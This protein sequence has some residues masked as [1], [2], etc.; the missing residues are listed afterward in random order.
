M[1]ETR[2]HIYTVPEAARH[3]RLSE[4]TVRKLI[5]DGALRSVKAGTKP[6]IADLAIEEYIGNVPKP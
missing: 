6:L 1:E 3:M 4:N 5:R 2:Q